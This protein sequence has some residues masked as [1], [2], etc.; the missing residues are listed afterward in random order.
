MLPYAF[1]LMVLFVGS[2]MANVLAGK[3][4]LLFFYQ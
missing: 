1:L 4:Q 3:W 2:S